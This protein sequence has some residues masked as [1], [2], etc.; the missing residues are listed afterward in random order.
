LSIKHNTVADRI[1]NPFLLPN[2]ILQTI[3]TPQGKMNGLL[4]YKWTVA[5]YTVGII[6]HQFCRA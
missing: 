3:D 6:A 2:A 5:F 4:R 1:T